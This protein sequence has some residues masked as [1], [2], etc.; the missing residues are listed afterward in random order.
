M[1]IHAQHIQ[2][3]SAKAIPEVSVLG[4]LFSEVVAACTQH[5]GKLTAVW[6]RDQLTTGLST[7][8]HSTS[9]KHLLRL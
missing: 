4:L 9:K 2:E 3:E 1:H 8:T 7:S 6:Q 5:A